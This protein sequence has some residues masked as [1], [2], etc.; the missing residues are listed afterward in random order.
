MV[1]LRV[2]SV[3]TFCVRPLFPVQ[4]DIIQTQL[5]WI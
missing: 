2:L 5:R 1:C 4:G 3:F